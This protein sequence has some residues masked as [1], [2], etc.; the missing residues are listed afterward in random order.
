M[1]LNQKLEVLLQDDLYFGVEQLYAEVT[2]THESKILPP[3]LQKDV[4]RLYQYLLDKM[5]VVESKRSTTLYNTLSNY[6]GKI[7]YNQYWLVNLNLFFFDLGS[8]INFM[9]YLR[10]DYK[11][12]SIYFQTLLIHP[13]NIIIKINTEHICPVLIFIINLYLEYDLYNLYHNK[14]Q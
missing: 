10:I 11:I 2:K 6:I 7:V 12:W 5:I 3:I 4:D 8:S 13:T 14:C 9:V 1:C